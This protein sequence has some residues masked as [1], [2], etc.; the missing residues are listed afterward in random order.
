MLPRCLLLLALVGMSLPASTVE[1]TG[2]VGLELR[3]F[4]HSPQHPGQRPQA[5]SVFVEP[6]L[7]WS[8]AT[9]RNS[10]LF[11]PFLRIDSSDPQRTHADVRELLFQH[12]GESWELRAGIG[13]VFWGVTESRHLVDVINQTDSVEDIDG[14]DKLGQPMLNVS[15][16]RNWGTLDLFALPYFRARTFPGRRGRLR[17]EPR[18]DADAARYESAAEARR[19]DWAVRYSHTLGDWDV[20]LAH[21]YGTN[22]EPALLPRL[23]TDGE[24][25]LIPLY[26]IIQQ[27]S[28]DV[29]VT[30]GNWLWKLE[31]LRRR[32]DGEPF[33][34]LVSGFE[35]TFVGVGNSV[36]DLG[37]LMEIHYDDRGDQAPHP[38]DRDAFF[39]I[40]LA[41]NDEDGTELLV[42][43]IRD[44]GQ[45]AT[46]FS[47]EAS[48]RI[49]EWWKIEA[50]ARIW[51]GVATTDPQHGLSGDDYAQLVLQR[52]F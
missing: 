23:R 8:D 35:Y 37:V 5:G 9:G 15:L 24:L 26:R 6:E 45:S 11:T 41:L 30:Q 38:F 7:Y 17:S 33:S 27:T 16:V 19:L 32:G 46:A 13:K 40:R 12:V 25:V 1:L 52:Y 14:E 49:G 31:A 47:V 18:V 39:G 4:L 44:A 3:G 10:V 34:A 28:I 20:G 22:R 2:L 48:R 29:Q 51:A 21:F 42:G 36:M 50:Q 43:A